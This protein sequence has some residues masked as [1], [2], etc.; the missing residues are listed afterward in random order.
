MDTGQH[1]EDRF[2]YGL[3]PKIREMVH[4]WKPSLVAE[5]IGL[6]RY[7]E[8]HLYL[9]HGNKTIFPQRSSFM[10]KAPR[11]FSRGGTLR[12]P[13]YGNKV[14]PR[15]LIMEISMV[16]TAASRT[17]ENHGQTRAATSRDRGLRRRSSFQR[18]P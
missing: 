15:A 2:I 5:V 7:F 17:H 3:N 14:V 6:A 18:T 10:G 9:K 8:E 16:C 12:P 11:T 4:T 1:Q 13:P